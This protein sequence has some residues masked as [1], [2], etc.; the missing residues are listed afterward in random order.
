MILGI[1]R[2]FN[3][4]YIVSLNGPGNPKIT[5]ETSYSRVIRRY[6]DL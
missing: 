6:F 5:I 3:N 1:H 2:Y 4:R